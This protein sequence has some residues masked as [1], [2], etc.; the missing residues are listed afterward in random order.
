MDKYRGI[1][2]LPLV[3]SKVNHLLGRLATNRSI[4]SYRTQEELVRA[5]ASISSIILDGFDKRIY[6]LPL[7]VAGTP[8]SEEALNLYLLG[9]YSEISYLLN[10]VKN[11]AEMAEE[12]FNFAVARIR[13]LQAGIK[14]CRRHL[15]TYALYATQ[16][17]NTLHFGETFSTEVD[18][19]RGSSLLGQ[20][21]CFIDLAE[22]TVSLPRISGS[23]IW[24][25]ETVEVGSYSNGVLG[26]NVEAGTP[27][28]G[29]IQAIYDGNIDT[30]TEYERVVDAE[31]LEGLTLE[32]KIKLSDVQPV[33]GIKIHPIFLG[34][35][36]PYSISEIKV[37]S[38]G[39]DWISLKDEVRV[40]DFLDED[41]EERYHLSP[42]SSRFSGEFN[43]TFAPRFIKFLNISFNQTS[44]F[45]IND[46]YDVRRFRYVIAIKEIEIYGHKYS[47]VGELVSKPINF[48][49]NISALGISSLIDPPFVPREVGGADYFISFDDG[50]S[51]SQVRSL[52]ESDLNIPEVLYPETEVTSLR[53]KL[54]LFKDE[55]AFAQQT[56]DV[57]TKS[58]SEKVPW[59]ARRPF[60]INL[61]HK[62]IEDTITICDPQVCSRG[63]LYPKTVLGYGVPSSITE[64]AGGGY[65]RQGNIEL[66][67]KLPLQYVK[68]PSTIYLFVNNILWSRV[69]TTAN[70]SYFWDRQYV[71][72]RNLSP[73]SGKAGDWE[74]VFGDG[75]AENP[76]GSI[77]SSADEISLY[78]AEEASVV[79]GLAAPYKLKLEYPSDGIKENTII[80][81]FSGVFVGP[82]E[83]LPSLATKINLQK[84]NVLVGEAYR[85]TFHPFKVSIRNASGFVFS[86]SSADSTP[87]GSGSFQNFKPFINGNSELLADGDWTVDAKEGI[88]YLWTATEANKEYTASYWW[89]DSYDLSL[90]DWNFVEGT[91]DE[92]EVYESGYKTLSD[93]SL[94]GTHATAGHTSMLI[95][96][97]SDIIKGIVKKSFKIEDGEI[98]G[99]RAYEIP[100]IDGRTEFL[101]RAKIQDES[102]PSLI[103]DINSI[104][105]FRLTHWQTLIPT[106]SPSFSDT[107][108]YF[109][110]EKSS[111][112]GCT[113]LGDYFFD[114]TGIAG[115]GVG[116]IYL[117]I[118]SPGI[119]FIETITVSYQY[120]DV[121]STERMKGSFSI[122]ASTG[123]V[124]FA[125]PLLAADLTKEI[126]FKYTRYK[127]SYNISSV[128]TKEKDYLVNAEE[129][130]ITVLTGAVGINQNFLM[131]N[132]KYQPEVTRTLDLAPYYSPLVRALDIKVS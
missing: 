101:G 65:F 78:L 3:E 41:P 36:T 61:F 12:N 9:L 37:S 93:S 117:N 118:G 122:D 39:R 31:D 35:R 80:R 16:F 98:G 30:W 82:T 56:E 25:I 99:Y 26:S 14:Y 62:P 113:I 32:L 40:A 43:I 55:M 121:L 83:T 44:A 51:W 24:K 66:R 63:K 79:E 46:I 52:D 48:T 108:T 13:T 38:D 71:I 27:T 72:E 47:A 85:G 126:S 100:F 77:P 22:G 95:S 74:V 8:V 130:K 119:P 7:A 104:V 42:H 75:E 107:T 1:T 19:D 128:L 76:T 10:A 103:S 81:S 5:Y 2:R 86:T 106:S 54:H 102:I 28:R 129:S 132:Y 45:P 97:S 18:L 87:P 68:D 59:S 90:D 73:D 20:E 84:K 125:Q 21:E 127:T 11:T 123:I 33:N 109:I 49:K 4:G 91:L 112:A 94:I 17:G 34:A 15:S 50:S 110:E 29:S 124:H 60:V 92:I 131:V 105:R 69:A 70:F 88:I 67:L 58:F 96:I 6:D 64:S 120:A 53:Y 116:Y 57:P 114:A 115:D 89:E 111:L 23:D